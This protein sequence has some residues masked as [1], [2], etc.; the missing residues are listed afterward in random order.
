MKKILSIL[1]V[2]ATLTASAQVTTNHGGGSTGGGGGSYTASNGI[3]ISGSVIKL[4][5]SLSQPTSIYGI[6]PLTL[7]AVSAFYL[8]SDTIY[9]DLGGFRFLHTTSNNGGGWNYGNMWMGYKA[10]QTFA[11][12]STG[13]A[14]TGF[15]RYV[16]KS[17]NGSSSTAA[18]NAAF[19]AGAQESMTTGTLNT[20]IG[21]TSQG[22]LTTVTGL[23]TVG[24]HSGLYSTGADNATFVGRSAGDTCTAIETVAIGYYSQH[25]TYGLGNVGLG[26]YS[27]YENSSG[28]KNTNLGWSAGKN[29][30]TATENTHVGYLA[31]GTGVGTVGYNTYVGANSGRNSS[32][33]N[34]NA[35]LGRTTMEALTTGIGNVALGNNAMSTGNWSNSIVIGRSINVTGNYQLNLGGALFADNIYST[36]PR[37]AFGKAAGTNSTLDMGGC[38]LPIILPKTGTTPSVS[39]ESAMLYYNTNTNNIDYYDGTY[40][41]AIQKGVPITTTTSASGVSWGSGNTPQI[42]LDATSNA[43]TQTI[44]SHSSTYKGWVV[45]YKIILAS[46]N[47]V[48]FAIPSSAVY[49]GVTGATSFVASNG[50]TVEV[51]NDG[52]QWVITQY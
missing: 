30:T 52:T 39:L 32:S 46:V 15:G 48:T 19:G 17:L 49:N 11:T 35:S 21:V 42:V 3:G 13:Y 38:S 9:N 41:S 6:H 20:A 1:L 24:H 37:F 47:A 8:Y 28:N 18:S 16:Q 10:G 34:S 23:T 22:L 31:G 12:S 33:G 2:A 43:I 40:W 5:G 44:P 14:N 27:G 50:K 7:G 45:K 29:V 4:G 25:K 51:T 26:A 36:T